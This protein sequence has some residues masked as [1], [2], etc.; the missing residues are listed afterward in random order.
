MP[1]TLT[2]QVY[3]LANVSLDRTAKKT[4]I[5]EKG[6]LIPWYAHNALNMEGGISPTLVAQHGYQARQKLAEK[7]F[8][9]APIR[10]QLLDNWCGEYGKL[11][12]TE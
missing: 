4:R 1:V 8:P 9:E 7:G 6:F 11:S 5:P 10:Y 2:P 3:R 12:K